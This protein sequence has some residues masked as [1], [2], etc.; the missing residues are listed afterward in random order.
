MLTHLE[1]KHAESPGSLQSSHHEGALPN[2]VSKPE[3]ILDSLGVG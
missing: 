2:S 1:T 3:G